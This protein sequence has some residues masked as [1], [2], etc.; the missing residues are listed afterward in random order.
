[1]KSIL[2]IIDFCV[3]GMSLLSD[4]PDAP[5]CPNFL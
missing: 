3:I 1:M 4:A 5:T 2:L